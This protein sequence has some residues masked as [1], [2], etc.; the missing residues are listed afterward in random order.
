MRKKVAAIKTLTWF[1]ISD[2]IICILFAIVVLVYNYKGIEVSDALIQYFYTFFG[3]EFGATA[4][5]K[6]SKSVIANKEVEERIKKAKE[7]NLPVEKADLK[8]TDDIDYNTG[9]Y[10]G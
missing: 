10:Y 9:E 5:I 1:V 7:N 8:P 2:F 6:I 4:A 3:L